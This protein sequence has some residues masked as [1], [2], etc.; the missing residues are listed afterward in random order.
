FAQNDAISQLTSNMAA[1]QAAIDALSVLNPQA[2][3]Q[4]QRAADFA[5]FAS[6]LYQLPQQP[7]IPTPGHHEEEVT[8]D[9]A[10]RLYDLQVLVQKT[11]ANGTFDYGQFQ[12]VAR[13]AYASLAPEI[14]R[15]TTYQEFLNG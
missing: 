9:N 7:N 2:A 13:E 10:K 12:T 14:Q 4:G 15:Y 3:A 11:L 6:S 1:Y 5:T 8:I